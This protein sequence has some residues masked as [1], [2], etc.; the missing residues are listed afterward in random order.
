ML[1]R[2]IA[3]PFLKSTSF[4]LPNPTTVQLTNGINLHFIAGVQQDIIKIEFI[5]KAGKWF[6]SKVGLSHFTAQM[7]ERGTTEKT[8]AELAEFF[9]RYGAHIEISPGLDFTSIALYSLSKNLHQVFPAFSEMVRTPTFP[10]SELRH[11]KEV[12]IQNLKVNNE[13]NSVLASK[14]LRKNIFGSTHPYGSSIEQEDVNNL[15]RTDLF[16]YFNEYL[17]PSEIFVV[18]KEDKS[19]MDYIIKSA[20]VFLS[21]HTRDKILPRQLSSPFLQKKDKSNS[22]QSSVRLGKK[23]ISR[24]HSDYFNLLF[25]N[26][27]LGGYFGSR[28]MK[29]IR[30]EKGLTYGIQSSLNSLVN[31]SFIVIG[32]DVNK[33]NETLIF[34]EIKNEITQLQTIKI[35]DEELEAAI[36]HFTGSLQSE[37]ANPFSVAEKIKTIK[38]FSLPDNYYQSLLEKVYSIN[39]NQLLS[40]AQS[41]LN[42]DELFKVVVG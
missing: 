27:I 33:E 3:P 25:L 34:Q 21:P 1:D 28:L 39:S 6:E 24:N 12:F 18:S 11:M 38:L 5:F 35:K 32:A 15:N 19:T 41:H 20:D 2:K 29:N 26:H 13:K 36:G 8:S 37:T 9:D 4:I 40:T 17:I 16:Q 14:A 31:E 42:E 23:T 7:M 22:V 10:E 30:E